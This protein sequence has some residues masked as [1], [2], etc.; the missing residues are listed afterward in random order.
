MPTNTATFCAECDNMSRANKSDPP[1]RWLCLKFPRREGFGY[2]TRDTWDDF[3]PYA[4]A[5]DINHGSCPLWTARREPQQKET[6][7]G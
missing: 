5:K 7:N 4:Y 3:P 6:A 2:V 1:W